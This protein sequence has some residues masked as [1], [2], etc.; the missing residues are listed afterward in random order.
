[1]T[2][3]MDETEPANQTGPDHDPGVDLIW[4]VD[5]DVRD[6]P[7]AAFIDEVRRTFPTEP[8]IDRTLTR[9]MH[10]RSGPAYQRPSLEELA[11][12]L[13][14]FLRHELGDV[15]F[16]VV[17]LHWFTGGVSKIQVGFVLERREPDGSTRSDH[18]V[19]RM[20]PSEGSNATSRAREFELLRLLKGTVPVPETYFIDAEGEFF[21]E[22]AL[23]YAFAEGVTKPRVATTGKISGLGT[24]F[25]DHRRLLAP[26]YLQHLSAIH[27]ADFRGHE[28]STLA[29]PEAGTTQAAEWAVNHALRCW[30]E[31]RGEDS[32]LMEVAARWLRR[33]L[34]T[35]D[36]A[37]VVHGDFRSGNFLFDEDSGRINAWLDWERGL[38]GD[39]H[40]DLAWITLP[41]MGHYDAEGTYWV[42][43]LVP[44]D[45]FFT[46][47]EQV[48]GLTVDPER[49]RF[50]QVLCC[51]SIIVSTMASSYRIARLGKSHQDIL[52]TR[53]EGMVPVISRVL[54]DLLKEPVT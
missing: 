32:P 36:V 50:Y 35:L 10:H 46:T 1:M 37:S 12:H 24:N 8:E 14:T 31:D 26:Q 29:V 33:N 7:S 27:N 22:P 18:M 30:E 49:L 54:I 19:V 52:L 15:E 38:I 2:A 11:K 34:P 23:I 28:F 17:D 4:D 20:D 6:A 44:L 45:E 41:T 40:R 42:C 43:G 13:E 3:S 48:S 16:E 21:P 47:Y 39:R 9:K 5:F 25:G 53:V 51:F